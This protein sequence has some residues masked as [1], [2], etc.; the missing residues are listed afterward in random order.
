M[1]KHK[2]LSKGLFPFRAFLKVLA[3]FF[4]LILIGLATLTVIFRNPPSKQQVE[5]MFGR[6]P[7]QIL[8]YKVWDRTPYILFTFNEGSFHN[9][10]VFDRIERQGI[11]ANWG[12]SGVWYYMESTKEPASLGIGYC[13]GELHVLPPQCESTDI[14]GQINDR[15]ITALEMEVNGKKHKF[16]VSYPGFAIRLEHFSGEPINFKWFD[17]Q[18]NLIMEGREK[19]CRDNSEYNSQACAL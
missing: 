10:V 8:A 18:N 9:L 11:G 3:V 7:R 2:S 13:T 1:S 6:S 14:F 12:Q 5:D 4:I 19:P 16:P 17:N 15:R